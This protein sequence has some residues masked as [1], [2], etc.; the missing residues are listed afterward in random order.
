MATGGG[1]RDLNVKL[2]LDTSHFTQ[3]QQ[4]LKSELSALKSDFKSVA[5]D[6]DFV[7]QSDALKQNLLDQMTA[8]EKQIANY[9][10]K[11]TALEGQLEGKEAGSKG[12]SYILRQMNLVKGSISDSQTVLS[13]LEEQMKT[14]NA[15]NFAAAMQE[16]SSVVN[17]LDMAYNTLLGGWAGD[18]ADSAYEVATDRERAAAEM[19]KVAEG[20]TVEWFERTKDR[21][22][23]AILDIPVTFAHYMNLM[24]DSMQA[25]GIPYQEAADFAE[26]FSKLEVAAPKLVGSEGVAQFSKFLNLMQV[27]PGEYENAAS[28][29]TALGNNFAAFEDQI[30]EVAQRSGSAMSSVGFEI[31][32]ALAVSAAALALGMEPAAAASSVEKLLT[33]LSTGAQMAS[34]SYQELIEKIEE[35]SKGTINSVYDMQA[36]IDANGKERSAFRSFMGMTA[37]DLSNWM[38]AA[39]Y[40]EKYAEIMGGTVEEFGRKWAGDP[41]KTMV[42]FFATISQLDDTQETGLSHALR[43]LGITEIRESRLAKNIT[44]NADTVMEALEISRAAFEENTALEQEYQRLR[45]TESS[46]RILRRNAQENA[47]ADLGDAVTAI[48]TP[49]QDFFADVQQGFTN[50]PEWAK[51][52]AGGLLEVFGGIGTVLSGVGDVAG[53]L[54]YSGELIKNVKSADWG[55]IGGGLKTVAGAVGKIALPVAAAAGIAALISTLDTMANDA[56]VIS[57]RLAAVEINVDEDSKNATL[58]AIAEVKRAAAELS[59]AELSEAYAGT[60]AVVKQGYGTFNMFG[61]A[62]GYEQEKAEREAEAIYADYGQR[63]QQLQQQLLAS[64]TSGEKDAI[65]AQIRS[66]ETAM[67]AAIAAN[68]DS[69]TRELNALVNGAIAQQEGASE[70][71]AAV[72]RKYDAMQLLYQYNGL[73]M[74]TKESREFWRTYG[75]EITATAEEYGVTLFDRLGNV[76]IVGATQALYKSAADDVAAIVG[77]EGGLMGIMSAV[78]SS[79]SLENADLT[80]LQGGMEALF[81]ALDFYQI[82]QQGAK[83]WRDIGAYSMTGLA[84]GTKDAKGQPIS[85]IE[86]IG[87]EMLDAIRTVLEL[88]SPSRAFA[89]IGQNAVQGLAAG[90]LAQESA[91][92]AAIRKI[93]AAMQAEAAAQAGRISALLQLGGYGVSAGLQGGY[94]APAGGS[95]QIT[96]HFN[97]SAGSLAEQQS[98]ISLADRI[99]RIQYRTNAGVGKFK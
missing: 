33:K 98:V 65:Q 81:Q 70:R 3:N 54:Y 83:N 76:D 75:S 93:G 8:V 37:S 34:G 14:F 74:G 92:V 6:S 10:Q 88:H 66:T 80:A 12:E 77:Q 43:M 44:L 82:A 47:L 52:A 48:R 18:A 22:E 64:T 7:G 25:G 53:G 89:E 45:N 68:Y 69:Y 20:A 58:A 50:L 15:G 95:S 59:G 51:N 23:N 73:G 28:A 49:F 13:N 30:L 84:S 36:A 9:Q 21:A 99:Q 85:E 97:I 94:N 62:L 41:A 67:E 91:A 86:A 96:N 40:A 11:L 61:Q 72:S 78:L 16:L 2:T 29:L 79:G 5:A 32:D 55:K 39:I 87:S 24:E 90:I 17:G 56:S 71:L 57:E 35:Y 19:L 63:L 46:H 1:P 38:Q 42:D 27:V 60:S 4:L 26:V 31:A